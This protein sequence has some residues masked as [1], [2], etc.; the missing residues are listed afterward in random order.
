MLWPW[1]TILALGELTSID[2]DSACEE[3]AD[4]VD[5]VDRSY[6]GIMGPD[7]E[8]FY[9]K[10]HTSPPRRPARRQ[11]EAPDPRSRLGAAAEVGPALAGAGTIP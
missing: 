5:W 7:G 4:S 8:V 10:R 6:S 1:L 9:Y 2:N 3:G 11:A